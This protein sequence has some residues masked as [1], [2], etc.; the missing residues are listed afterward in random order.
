MVEGTDERDYYSGRVTEAS[1]AQRDHVAARGE[2]DAQRAE[3]D[4]S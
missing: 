1:A 2:T 4:A 3:R